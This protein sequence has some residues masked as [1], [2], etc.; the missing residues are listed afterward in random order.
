MKSQQ[1]GK[2]IEE[3]RIEKDITQ[4]QL[5]QL[6][7]INLETLKKIEKGQAKV[8]TEIIWD[9]HKIF[10]VSVDEILNAQRGKK[11]KNKHDALVSL[12]SKEKKKYDKFKRIASA[13]LVFLILITVT[14]GYL[15]YKNRDWG[16]ILKGESEN[17][18]HDNS[19]FLYS[20]G[21]YYFMFGN[22]EFK[23]SSI[24]EDDIVYVELK[25]GD[26]L[27]IGSSDFLSGST[28]ENKGYDELFPKEVANNVNN[29]YYEITYIVDGEKTTEILDIESESI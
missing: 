26:R 20:N 15:S 19:I 10:D 8:T 16:Y 25:C 18:I 5:A 29:W 7:N 27:I 14:I 9:L 3:L 21:T 22:F 2:F 1:I 24:S 11:K 17:F 4:E 13:I 12:L 23:N 28:K 6:I